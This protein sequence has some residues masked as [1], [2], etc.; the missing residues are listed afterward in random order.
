MN[1]TELYQNEEVPNLN[2]VSFHIG[3]LWE[4]CFT[5]IDIEKEN[6]K[7]KKKK[8]EVLFGGKCY[9][10]SKSKKYLLYQLEYSIMLFQIG[11]IVFDK[12]WFLTSG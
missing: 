5:L 11:V 6:T 12:S 2:W 3:L 9:M 7:K 1:F 10:N 8:K 4:D